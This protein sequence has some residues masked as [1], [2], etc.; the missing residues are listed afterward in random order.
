MDVQEQ[1]N[2]DLQTV[3][4]LV[5]EIKF[6]M[7]TTEE[8][9]GTLRSR[10]MSTMQ[11]EANGDLWFFT[12]LSSPKIDEAEQH[13][14]VNLSYAR[15]D[16]QDY[17]SI[18]GF[19]EVVRD[20]AK[21]AQLWTPWIKPWFPDG[22]DDPDLVLLRVRITEAEYWDAPGS[23]VKRLYG[24]AKGIVTGDTSGL[25]DNGKVRLQT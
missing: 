4:D 5:K 10:P 18:S 1:D 22:L 2:P 7:L 20:K 9:D 24:L 14:Q 19:S 15:I 6:A 25:G 23:M 3:A 11:M 8:P 16:K 13:R 12:S 21:M 17:V